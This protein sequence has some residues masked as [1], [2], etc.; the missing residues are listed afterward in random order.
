VGPARPSRR[1][2]KGKRPKPK[3]LH[4]L[5]ERIGLEV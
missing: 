3:T 4:E 1:Q 2:S 5:L